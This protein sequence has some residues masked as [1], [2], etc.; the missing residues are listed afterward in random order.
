M[1]NIRYTN[2]GVCLVDRLAS[3]ATKYSEYLIALRLVIRLVFC[4]QLQRNH[5]MFH[6][7]LVARVYA[8]VPRDGLVVSV[9][10]S[11]AE[12]TGFKSQPRRCRVTVLGK[13]G[14]LQA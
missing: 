14:Q 5:A 11:G 8:A 6:A 10:D 4:R 1:Y 9:L 13:R 3:K 2:T 12:G 7:I